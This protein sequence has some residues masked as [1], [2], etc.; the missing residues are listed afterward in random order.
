M[1]WLTH[2]HRDYDEEVIFVLL[3]YGR[4]G[5]TVY[6]SIITILHGRVNVSNVPLTQLLTNR[7]ACWDLENKDANI[8]NELTHSTITGTATIKR[9]TGG[10]RQPVRIEQKNVKAHD[11]IL[12][13]KLFFNANKMPL[14][15]DDSDAYN[16]RV[17]IIAFPRRFDGVKEDR[18]L[19]AKLSTDEE[20]SGIF[21]VLMIAL[22]RIRKTKE[23]YEHEKS[24]EQKAIKYQMAV[25]PIEAFLDE[26]IS[27][28]SIVD[29]RTEKQTLHNAYER[30]CKKHQ[31]P[32]LKYDTFC[33][34]IKNKD[35]ADGRVGKDDREYYWKGIKLVPEYLVEMQQTTFDI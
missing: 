20:L 8:D 21:N 6:T 23:I 4:N 7:F 16:R 35:Y 25:D 2:S 27:P 11:A 10:S 32:I 9:L 22:R 26:A 12:Y 31:L 30:F 18:H 1:Q 15:D 29:D 19:T 17:I 28:Q 34:H 24:I 14:S 33:K 13:A 3:G 5:K